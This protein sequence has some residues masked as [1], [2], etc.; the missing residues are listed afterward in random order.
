MRDERKVE[1]T[2]I[3]PESVFGYPRPY[4]TVRLAGIR[5][6]AIRA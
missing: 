5:R 1:K 4:G 6:A 3:G 2:N